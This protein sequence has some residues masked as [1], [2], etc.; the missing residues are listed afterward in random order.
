MDN[1]A[2][3]LSSIENAQRRQKLCCFLP[4]SKKTQHILHI[5]FIEGYIR[6]FK[7]NQGFQVYLKYSEDREEGSSLFKI[8]RISKPGKKIYIPAKKINKIKRGLGILIL[9]TSKGVLSDR[10][11]RYLQLGG[12]VVAAVY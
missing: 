11:A 2:N 12:E 5:L 4:F 8:K 1:I 3:I 6:G 7:I 9:S 10:D